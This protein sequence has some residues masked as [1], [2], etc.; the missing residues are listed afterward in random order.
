M[1]RRLFERRPAVTPH[2]EANRR[3][4][5]ELAPLHFRSA[6][7]DVDGFKAGKSTLHSL[8]I[9][10]VGDVTG[11]TLL[12]L[13]CHFGLDTLSWARRGARVVGV[14]A[15]SEAIELARS[16]AGEVGLPAGFLCARVQDLP[17]LPELTPG[18]FDVVFTSYGVLC[19]LPDLR[20]WARTIVHF[21]KPDGIFYIVESHP[22]TDVFADA[23]GETD[24][25]LAYP[26]FPGPAPLTEEVP[27]SYADRTAVV[28]N[29][30]SH[31]WI[32]SLGEV[33]TVLT[34]AG[35]RPE[36]LHEHTC[37]V[38]QRFPWMKQEPT[39]GGACRNRSVR[40]YRCCFRCVRA[41]NDRPAGEP[42]MGFQDNLKKY[43]VAKE[44]SQADA[45]LA[46][47]CPLGPTPTGSAA[48]VSR[49]WRRCGNSPRPSA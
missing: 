20:P 26:Y 2:E 23:A 45:A 48:S 15:S 8:E 46:A 11:K 39:A 49:R 34:E 6:F 10:E 18:G 44:C 38:F 13:Q 9:E 1:K 36:F 41:G 30:T 7:Y 33:V 28:A 25:R 42:A 24:L 29:R 27:G 32:H 37:T 16:L 17:A 14:D 21:L 40:R 12:H 5:D 35:L 19:W 31:V 47:A 22:F 3:R 43:R 4:W